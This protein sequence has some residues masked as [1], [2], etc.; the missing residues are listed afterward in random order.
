MST[1]VFILTGGEVL[2]LVV[3]WP[4]GGLVSDP[5]GQDEAGIALSKQHVNFSDA[6]LRLFVLGIGN[7]ISSDVCKKLAA[8]GGGNHLSQSSKIVSCRNAPACSVQTGFPRSQA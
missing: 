8:T 5:L 4:L 3:E 2:R 1:A 6:L 7:T